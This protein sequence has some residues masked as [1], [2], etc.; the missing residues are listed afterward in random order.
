MLTLGKDRFVT[1]I[2]EQIELGNEL[3]GMPVERE[4]D[5]RRIEVQFDKWHDVN[6]R[7]L[8]ECSDDD[9]LLKDYRDIRFG[10]RSYFPTAWRQNYEAARMNLTR[11]IA[12]LEGLLEVLALAPRGQA[13]VEV[14]NMPGDRRTVFVVH[15]RDDRLRREFFDFL[16]SVGLTPLEWE[17]AVAGTGKA[18]PYIAEILENAF[19]TAA[20]IIVLLTPD[21]EARLHERLRLPHDPPSEYE[22]TPQARPNVLFEAGMAFAKNPDRTV[23]VSIGHMRPFSDVAG[24]HIVFLD[25][26][27]ERRLTLLQR[28]RICTDAW[29]DGTDWLSVGHFSIDNVA[30][31]QPATSPRS[32]ISSLNA[33]QRHLLQQ[34]VDADTKVTPRQPFFVG[35]FLT[36]TLV[37]HPG[38]GDGELAVNP[39]DLNELEELGLI[40]CR[41][42]AGQVISLDVTNS[43]KE[44]F[45]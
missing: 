3:L 14:R 38:V 30:D 4:E 20:A 35:N 31:Q 45:K 19:D 33:E 34:L 12:K 7:L 18:S 27:A 9:S 25:D 13:A 21:D 2:Q 26:T 29:V 41:R 28:L 5:V 24:R 23:L 15:G 42:E 10:S 37:V 16:R 8:I 44:S 1:L 40:R 22:L 6:C 43:G 36:G 39:A 11:R 32:R 17:T